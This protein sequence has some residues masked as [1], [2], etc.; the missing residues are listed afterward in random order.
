MTTV[1]NTN[2]DSFMFMTGVMSCLS[3]VLSTPLQIK[4]Y[5]FGLQLSVEEHGYSLKKT[6]YVQ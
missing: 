1:I 6:L 2:K 5:L 3:H 4:C